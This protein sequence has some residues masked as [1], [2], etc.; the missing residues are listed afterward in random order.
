MDIIES[1][2]E[3]MQEYIDDMDRELAVIKKCQKTEKKR[4][5]FDGMRLGFVIAQKDL[6]EIQIDYEKELNNGR[7]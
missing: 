3:R 1:A 7:K 2:I 6:I 5:Y 4:A